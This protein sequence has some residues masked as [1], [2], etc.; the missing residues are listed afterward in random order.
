MRLPWQACGLTAV[1][2][3]SPLI[4]IYFAIW[5]EKFLPE[6]H[7]LKIALVV[8]SV[9]CFLAYPIAVGQVI[10]LWFWNVH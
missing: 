2:F 9:G 8:F 3:L 10:V 4:Y 7:W 5:S 1:T 6:R